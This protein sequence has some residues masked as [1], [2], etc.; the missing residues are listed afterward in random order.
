ML[1]EKK[2]YHGN[3]ANEI[4]PEDRKQWEPIRKTLRETG[5]VVIVIGADFTRKAERKE[6]R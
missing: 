2:I 1:S 3:P 6:E 5:E 4:T